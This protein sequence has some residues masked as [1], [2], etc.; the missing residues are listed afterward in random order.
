MPNAPGTTTDLAECGGLP[1][2]ASHWRLD[3][4]GAS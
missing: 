1:K 3:L 4:T 2:R